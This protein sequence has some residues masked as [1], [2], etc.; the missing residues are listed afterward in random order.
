MTLQEN[1][2]GERGGVGVPCGGPKRPSF[3]I[4]R[5]VLP[6]NTDVCDQKRENSATNCHCD[7][8]RGVR[9]PGLLS[10]SAFALFRTWG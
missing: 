7:V 3:S 6:R 1:R 4:V 2:S 5:S 9:G 10:L 8:P